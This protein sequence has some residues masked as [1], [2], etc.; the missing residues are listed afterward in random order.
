MMIGK[1][2]RATV[3]QA[4]LHYVGSITVDVDLLEAA[5]LYP[6]QRVDV[7]DV[8][9]GSRLTTYVIPGERGAGEICINGAAA[10]H[11]RPGDVV[12]LIA[13]GMMS[14][15]DARHHLPNVVFV[16]EKNKIV[17]ISDEPGQVPDGYDLEPSGVPIHEFQA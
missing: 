13:Y 11:V 9:N 10:H 4:D 5:D 17:E 6:G 1:I 2:H 16:D 8:T 12:I 3:T 14:S 7:V 15:A